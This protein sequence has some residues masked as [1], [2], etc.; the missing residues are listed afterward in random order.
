MYRRL[1]V[2]IYFIHNYAVIRQEFIL[3]NG[4]FIQLQCCLRYQIL[5]QRLTMFNQKCI[6][7][8]PSTRLVQM[9]NSSKGKR[10]KPHYSICN[11]PFFV[12]G[13]KSCEHFYLYIYEK[14]LRSCFFYWTCFLCKSQKDSKFDC[15]KW[16]NWTMQRKP[17]RNKS[18]FGCANF[19]ASLD[20][21]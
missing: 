13:S 8:S 2:R 11:K 7:M 4:F 1:D 14:K 12:G 19:L 3:I 15:R 9:K 5:K 10:E 21:A 18:S 16:M 6:S 20:N 17:R